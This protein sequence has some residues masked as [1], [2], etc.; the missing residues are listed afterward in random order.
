MKLSFAISLQKTGFNYIVSSNNWKKKLKLLADLGY[1]GVELGIRDPEK[2]NINVLRRALDG[3]KLQLSAIGT[4]QAYVDD[5]LSLSSLKDNIRIK[6][7]ERI[8]RNIDL[9]GLF[10]SK[11]IIGL[12][13]GGKEQQEAS[14]ALYNK[15]LLESTKRICDYAVSKNVVLALEPLNRYETGFLN[16]VEQTLAFIRKI[17]CRNLTLLLDTFHMNIEENNLLEPIQKGIKY[18][19]HLHLADNNR[20]CPGKGC[21]D[22]GKI[23]THLKRL[24]YKGYLSG[25]MLPVPTAEYCIK[26]FFKVIKPYVGGRL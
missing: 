16:N 2:L 24:G 15:N 21:I 11:V 18:L 3:Y 10:D 23:I 12:V 17:K 7:I 5:G 4:G 8:E 26:N 22:F 6:A 25:E 20:K 19:S 9:A 1:Q 14:P 13:R